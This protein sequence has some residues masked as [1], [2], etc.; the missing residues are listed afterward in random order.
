M[1]SLNTSVCSSGLGHRFITI[2][3]VVLDPKSHTLTVVNAGH[4]PPLLRSKRGQIKQLGTEISALPLGI[5]PE[6]R[7]AQAQVKFDAGDSLILAT[8]GVTEAMNPANEI[9]G[10]PR[11]TA[12][13]K[14]APAEAAPLGEAIVADVEAFCAGQAQRDDICLICFHRLVR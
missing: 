11:L 3:F 6:I 12:F 10:T 4:L 1:T 8:D 5:Q 2:A 13:L 9:Y 7:Y 14:K